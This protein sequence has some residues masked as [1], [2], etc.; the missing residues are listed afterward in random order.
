MPRRATY[1]VTLTLEERAMLKDMTSKGK[2]AAKKVLYARALLLLDEGEYGMERWKVDAVATAVGLSD[3]TLEHLKR[4]FVEDGLDSALERKVRESPPREIRFGGEFEAQL[5]KLACSK[6]PDGRDRWTVRLLR[7]KLIEL[8]IVDTVSAM[9]VCNTLKKT[10]LSLTR[11]DTGRFLRRTTQPT[12]RRWRMSSRCI[13]G[14][15][16]PKTPW[17]AWTSQASSS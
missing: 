17:F 12:W 8:K 9:T 11:A 13:H 1:R 16:T 3:R 2:I 6:A 4:R 7:D 5:V 10:N 15:T 14:H